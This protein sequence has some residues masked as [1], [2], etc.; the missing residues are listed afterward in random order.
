MRCTAAETEAPF[1]DWHVK[2]FVASGGGSVSVG[3]T[4]ANLPK[5]S[6][7]AVPIFAPTAMPLPTQHVTV[8]LLRVGPNQFVEPTMF[9]LDF[10]TV[11]VAFAMLSTSTPPSTTTLTVAGFEATPA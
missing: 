9:H 8:V 7:G 2:M 1:D 11:K 4:S 6:T 3:G 10:E 5:M